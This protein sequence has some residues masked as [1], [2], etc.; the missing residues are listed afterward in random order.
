M[1]I[2]PLSSALGANV[3]GVDLAAV[4]DAEF[5][6]IYQAWL[7]HGVLRIRGQ[8][9][10]D[11]QLERFSARFGPLEK[12]PVKLPE[13]KLRKMFDSLYVTPLSNIRKNG[14]PI[15]GLGNAEARWHSDMTYEETPPPASV[16]LSIEVPDEGGDTQFA[17]QQAALASLP[18]ALREQAGRI[19]IKHD[20]AH[21]SIG[22]LRVGFEEVDSPRESPGAVHPAILPP[23]GDRSRGP[24]PRP[25]RMGLRDGHGSGRERGVARRT[26]ELRGAA[27][28]RLDPEVDGR[29]RAH[30][31]QPSRP[32]SPERLPGSPTTTDETLP[33]AGARGLALPQ[34]GI[35]Q[36]GEE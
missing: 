20:A 13:E 3:D 31:G 4:T 9:L 32:S 23:P 35:D 11:P 19:E 30:L 7:D 2:T 24:L 28:E 16:L 17:C 29:R 12:I 5:E 26:L 6:T 27:R 25:A 14:K 10:D 22:Q 1:N 33:G 36:M 15:G 18:A 34:F 8:S 21:T